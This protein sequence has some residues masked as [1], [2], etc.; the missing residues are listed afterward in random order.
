MKQIS[1]K[2]LNQVMR[3]MMTDMQAELLNFFAQRLP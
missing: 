2:L 3:G 1:L